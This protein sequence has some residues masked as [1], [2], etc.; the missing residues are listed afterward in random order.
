MAMGPVQLTAAEANDRG[1]HGAANTMRARATRLDRWRAGAAALATG[2]LLAACSS[3]TSSPPSGNASP[4]ATPAA[5]SAAASA[6]PSPTSAVCQAA[7]ELRA[8]VDTLTHVKIGKGTANEIK[9]DLANVEAKLTALTAEMHGEFQTQTS[10]VKSALDTLKTAIS[11]FT[12][13]P[14]TSK[15]AAVATALGGVATATSNL[16]ASLAPR[17]GSA[18]ASPGP[19][20]SPSP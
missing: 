6:S 5:T 15:A 11:N 8:S 10:A 12:A 2:L 13:H 20:A 18:T 9:T 4:S 19:S 14:G 17:C 1:S 7:A 3:G 16:L